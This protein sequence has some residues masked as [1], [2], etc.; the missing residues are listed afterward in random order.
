M[1]PLA[2]LNSPEFSGQGSL[3]CESQTASG[4]AEDRDMQQTWVAA[5][6][7][8]ASFA[9][10][11]NS[12]LFESLRFPRILEVSGCWGIL[13]FPVSGQSEIGQA[14]HDANAAEHI[15]ELEFNN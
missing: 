12:G 10:W 1:H 11:W 5:Y 2:E 14:E 4:G 3:V 13:Q 15:H 6:P 8:M 9:F 7:C